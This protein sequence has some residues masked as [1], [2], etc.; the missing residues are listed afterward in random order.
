[1]SLTNPKN[2]KIFTQKHQ[3]MNVQQVFLMEE[4]TDDVALCN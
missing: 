4:R 2:V 3:H 1:M